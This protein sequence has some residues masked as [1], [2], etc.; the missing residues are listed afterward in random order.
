VI[1]GCCIGYHLLV[2]PTPGMRA[3]W[4]F[5]VGREGWACL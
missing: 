5:L 3:T 1:R 2:A 4:T